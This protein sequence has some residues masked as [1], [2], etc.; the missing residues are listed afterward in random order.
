MDKNMNRYVVIA[1][2]IQ[3]ATVLAGLLLMTANP[4]AAEQPGAPDGAGQSER[5]SSGSATVCEPS[6]LGSPYIPV[7]SW[8]YPAVLRLYSMGYVDHV[9]LGMRPWTRASLSNMLEDI[10]AQIEDANTY[11]VSTVGDAQDIYAALIR[12]LRYDAGMQCLTHQSN[13]HIE[14]VYS[15]VRGISGT[16]LRDSFHLGST[17]IN[18]YGRPY[19]NGFNNYSGASGYAAA[20]RF[21]LYVRGEF[22]G[23]PSAAGYSQTLAQALST[24]DGTTFLN[25]ATGL[26]YNQAT[27]PMG[28]IATT[29][30]GR[31]IEAY[32]SAHLL[33]HE[34]SFGKQDDWLGPG[35]GGGMAYSNNAEN[36]Y[37][38]RINRIEPLYIPLLS[39]LTGPF[40]YDFLV[41]GL[42]GHTYMPNPANPGGSNPNLPNVIDP[43]DPLVH[44]EKI[45]FRPTKNLE[46]G[47]ERTVIWGGE[48][49]EG[50]SIHS[51]LRSFFST[52]A[53]VGSINK[54][55]NNDP[56]ARFGAFDFSYR[57]PF[58]RNW[59]TLYADS[60]VHDDISPIDA[61]RRASW[62]PGLYL[63]HVPGIPKLDIRAEAATTDPSSSNGASQYGHFMYWETIQRQGYTNQGQLFGD[64]IG[65]ED[66]GGQAWIT[67]HLSGNEWL[68]VGL[69]NQKA[70]A[71]FIPGGTTLN[72]I[73]FQAVKRIGKDLE[74]NGKFAFERW[75]API[76]L[77]DQQTVTTT[78]IQLTWF[79]ER[80]INF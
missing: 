46:F 6:T 20:G 12:F 58:V 53:G 1:P 54:F 78:T 19:E 74:I 50:I 7:D 41:G 43:G 35:L 71:Y 69:R 30:D 16:P 76:Y 4:I 18:D 38:F 52:T 55:G 25:A 27:I 66:K 31:F 45:S 28:P 56:G 21:T 13:Y 61:P 8:V 73:N 2:V 63:S 22:Q 60:E 26:P 42:H 57:L 75:K 14:S 40:R 79:P 39:R 32:V 17:I 68:Q 48:G 36:I 15:V 80:K 72:D 70:T 5:D 44:V 29:T 37:S 47:F 11:G 51:F 34:I 10:D 67:Y 23:A 62:R 24:I 59:L 65:R 49:H 33:N 3:C 64:W 77:T 9:Y